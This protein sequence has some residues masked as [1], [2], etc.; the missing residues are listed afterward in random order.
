VPAAAAAPLADAPT[1]PAVIE[2]TNL[3]LGLAGVHDWSVA[4]PFVDVFRTARPWTGHLPGQFGGWGHDELA[5]GGWLDPETGWLRGI[6]PELT[7]V[8]AL[9]L[10][11]LPAEAVSAAGRYRVTWAGKGTLRLSGG[12]TLISQRPGEMWFSYTPN[13]GTVMLDILAIDPDDPIR[14]IVVVHERNLAAYEAGEIFDP[15]YLSRLRGVRMLRF[16]DWAQTNNSPVATVADLPRVTDYQ[17]TRR[18]VPLEIQIALANRLGADAWFNVPHLADDALIRHM[19]ET[20]RDRLDPSLTAYVE[21]SNEVWNFMFA[22]AEWAEQQGRARWGR[23]GL[24]AEAYAL[25]TVETGAI[26]AEVFGEAAPARLRRVIATQTGWIGREEAILNAPTWAA[27]VGPG[28]EPPW[29]RTDAYAIAGYFGYKL[30]ES[31]KA[32]MV[33]RWIRE[34]R[35]AAEAAARAQGLT[36]SAWA[37]HVEA[38]RFD[39]ARARAYQELRD[40]SLSGDDDDSLRRLLDDVLTHHARLAAAHGHALVMYEGGQHLVGIGNW[41]D[42]A[43]LTEFFVNL[44]FSAEM[45]ALYRELIDGWAGISPAPF[46]DFGEIQTPGR[47]GSWGALRHPTDDNPRWRALVAAR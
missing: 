25:R 26:W 45:G 22:Q 39:L 16:M 18:G 47:Y 9:I 34:S 8:S 3:A 24:Y 29:K 28:F 33:K 38:H 40:G 46:M 41:M 4:Q 12:A 21:F 36:G 10:T 31:P 14:D 27:E 43:E 15:L 32:G 1:G 35:R 20:V 23:P 6:P 42:D 5:A 19:A 44:N 7:H 30:G 17:W 11:D 13:P 37:A 2:N